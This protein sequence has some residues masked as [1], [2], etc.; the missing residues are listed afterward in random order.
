MK[1]EVQGVYLGSNDYPEP[2][3]FALK[4]TPLQRL[5]TIQPPNS[6][7]PYHISV[8]FFDPAERRSFTA[9]EQKYSEPRE[10]TLKGRIRGMAFYLDATDPI[11]SDPLIQSVHGK[12]H[13]AHKPLH[14][15]L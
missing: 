8:A 5:A 10:V 1:A 3:L 6:E 14:V 15:S 13:Y 4:V 9:L 7:T 2:P 12:G 11:A